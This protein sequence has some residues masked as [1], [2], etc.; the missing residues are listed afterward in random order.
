MFS[1]GTALAAGAAALSLALTPAVPAQAP[2]SG[3]AEIALS[4]PT[5][6]G[7]TLAATLHVPEQAA[8]G[9]PGMVLVHGA[10]PGKRDKYR[11]EAVVF[12]R[13]GVAT[14]TYDKRTAGYSLTQRS[15]SQLADDAAAAAAVLRRRPEVA[16]SVVGIWGFSE[17]G[18]VAPLAASRAAETAFVVVVG[19]NGVAPLRQ[20]TWADAA[21]M[22]H[23]GVEGSLVDASTRTF[24]RMISGLGMF[25]EP[26]YDP[27]PPV[28]ALTVPVLGIWGAKDRLTPPVESVDAFQVALEAGGNRHYTLRTFA[29]AEHSVRTTT[30]GFDKGAEFAPGYV[31]LVTAWIAA[32][33]KGAA[34]PMS[35]AGTGDQ[36]R[37]TTEVP[38]LAWHESVWVQMGVLVVMLAGFG[39]FWLV[40]GWRAVCRRGSATPRSARLLSGAGLVAML[41]GLSYL[42]F[43]QATRGRTFDPGPMLAG[44]PILWLALQAVAVVAVAAAVALGVHQWRARRDVLLL[45]PLTAGVVFVPWAAYWGLLLP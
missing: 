10:G 19:A 8:P 34:P 30:T 9:R 35:V 31:D 13:A 4:V 43:V 16:P 32:V 17:G 29:D 39:G 14:L 44:R 20:Q 21:K 26:Y 24:Y 28:R 11:E 23:A 40:M 33:A 36:P 15:Y 41:G 27:A 18:W 42:G 7:L 2:A 6:D 37:P 3:V 38:P 25:P 5:N 1:G 22:H 45:L 12:A